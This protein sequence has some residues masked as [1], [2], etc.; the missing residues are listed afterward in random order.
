M[1][2]EELLKKYKDGTATAE[3]VAAV[4]EELEKA[5]LIEEY[6]AQ[7]D[8]PLPLPEVSAMGEVKA[9]QRTIKNHTRRTALAVVT[10]VLAVLLLL[11]L[12]L[13]PLL[14]RRIY[15]RE[16]YQDG[17]DFSEYRMTMDVF[18]Q[19]FL[20]Q[21]DF[22][23]CG[24]ETS[25]FGRW[26]LINTFWGLPGEYVRADFTVTCGI[27]N[28]ESEGFWKLFPPVNLF[29]QEL[30]RAGDEALARLD[31]SISVAAAVSF[32]ENLTL[33]EVLEFRRQA[34]A[35][36]ANVTAAAISRQTGHTMFLR[37]EGG[38]LGW[39]EDVNSEY[40]H[41]YISRGK[42][43]DAQVMQQHLISQLQ[44][45]VDHDSIARKL[46]PY[47]SYDSFLKEAQNDEITYCGVWVT[48]TGAELLALYDTGVVSQIWA[49]EAHISLY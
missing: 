35:L 45:M 16:D 46:D 1:K 34:E 39:G 23:G 38:V 6:L 49:Q 41:L 11:Q 25:G 48:G 32:T 44:Y 18:T 19:L 12:V 2:F 29:S 20:P 9:V 22:Y 5:R 42:S 33:E 17:G 24:R 47:A 13:L 26:T 31:N 8:A 30:S 10:A 28:T 37:L 15:D 3:E 4:E 40:P 14:N 21:Y 43:Y 27:L 36:G 7:E